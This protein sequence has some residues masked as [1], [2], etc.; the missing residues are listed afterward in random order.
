MHGPISLVLVSPYVRIGFFF[1]IGI[2]R[3]LVFRRLKAPVRG[4]A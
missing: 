2:S 4:E 3:A 1:E